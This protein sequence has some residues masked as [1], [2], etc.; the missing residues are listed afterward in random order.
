LSKLGILPPSPPA[1]HAPLTLLVSLLAAGTL[2]SSCAT[3]NKGQAIF[4]SF[5]QCMAANGVGAIFL[6]VLAKELT[7]NNAVGIAAAAG[8][9]FVAWKKCGQAHQKVAV[10]DQRGRDAVIGDPRYRGAQGGVLAIDDLEVVSTKPGDDITTRYRFTYTSP[11]V[12][13]KDIPAKEKFVFLAG[14]Q[15]QRGATEFKEIEFTRDFVIQQ[16]QRRHEHSVPSDSSFG[17]FKPWKLRYQLEVDGRCQE[18]EATFDIA[19][20]RPG[21]AGPA[22]ACGSR[23]AAAPS[24]GGAKSEAAAPAAAAVVAP[25]ATRPAPVAQAPAPNP[26]LA[27][28]LRLQLQPRGALTGKALAA[29]TPVKVLET[30]KIGPANQPVSWV[31][32]ESASGDKGWTLESNLKR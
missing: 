19:G 15:N 5:N 4:A 31:H 2:A 6:G 29:G 26:T 24:G 32:V 14:F 27:R 23:V 11:D 25:P 13:K 18:T 12:A 21:R 16:G 1:P 22:V 30:R 9:L 7:G 8:T 20:G 10:S 17:Q 28:A 3:D